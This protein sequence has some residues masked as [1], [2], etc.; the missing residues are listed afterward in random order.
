[1]TLNH[2]LK[3]PKNAIK[4]K[5]LRDFTLPELPTRSEKVKFNYLTEYYA[6]PLFTDAAKLQTAKLTEVLKQTTNTR[7]VEEAATEIKSVSRDTLSAEEL[8]KTFQLEHIYNHEIEYF[9]PKKRHHFK[10]NLFLGS[11][12]YQVRKKTA[13][14]PKST[15]RQKKFRLD[16]LRAHLGLYHE[17]GYIVSFDPMTDEVIFT[18]SNLNNPQLKKERNNAKKL[19]GYL[20]IRL[21][22][23]N[24]FL[25][26][27]DVEGNCIV[28]KSG[29]AG[30]FVRRQR[31][32]A[33][34]AR[35]LARG[36]GDIARNKNFKNITIIFTPFNRIQRWRIK[37]VMQT[38]ERSGLSIIR[39][40]RKIVQPH[41]GCRK[42]KS[43]RL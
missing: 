4:I 16:M 26:L 10:Y 37:P 2:Q 40:Q 29:G 6:D 34:A 17:R 33:F 27:T 18:P 35:Q 28:T 36:V 20:Y 5:E 14:S 8:Q 32:N 38:L 13:R 25:T 19:D 24:M 43:R 7:K 23:R 1:M 11:A 39:V 22:R 21:T 3:L 12:A 15:L 31:Q 41:G 42:K 30:G 9:K